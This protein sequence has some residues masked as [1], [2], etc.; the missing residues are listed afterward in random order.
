[1]K[2]L[3]LFVFACGQEP[4]TVKVGDPA[5]DFSLPDQNEISLNLADFK[6]RK[7]FL[8]FYPKANTSG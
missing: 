2:K 1:M 4:V 7:L 6:G 8:F 5:P 3:F